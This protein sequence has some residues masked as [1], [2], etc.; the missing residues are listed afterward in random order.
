MDQPMPAGWRIDDLENAGLRIIQDPNGFCFGM[1][2]VLLA[3]FARAQSCDH[4]LDLGAGSGI[5]PLLLYGLYKPQ[6]IVGIEIQPSLVHMSSQSVQLNCLQE[7]IHVVCG[8]YRDVSLL[9]TLGRFNLVVTNPPYH[10]IGSGDLCHDK[11]ACMARF[12]L[13]STL[14]DVI[15]AAAVVLNEGGRFC[16][17]HLPK[18]LPEI[19]G[20]MD[21]YKLTPKRVVFVHPYVHKSASL[22]LIEGVKN[23]NGGLTVSPSLHVH[24]MDGKFTDTMEQIYHGGRLL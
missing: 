1:D 12:E 20:V 6:Y 3:H 4:V 10:P 24:K 15:R 18:R 7:R 21:K 23:A 17:V 2:A 13:T 11:S 22:M 5:L 8:D 9:H 14:D 16:M 19:I